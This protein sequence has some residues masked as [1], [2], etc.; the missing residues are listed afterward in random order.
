MM[1][2]GKKTQDSNVSLLN[3][4]CAARKRASGYIQ[5]ICWCWYVRAFSHYGHLELLYM[6]VQMGK[7][8][9]V[10]FIYFRMMF[11]VLITEQ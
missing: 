3:P 5:G 1:G 2:R 6:P 11:E 10:F 4:V 8:A 7:G 9:C